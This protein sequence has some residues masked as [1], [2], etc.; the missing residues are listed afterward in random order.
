VGT[1]AKIAIGCVAVA[2]AMGI[3]A[4]VAVGGLAFWAKGKA[5]QFTSEQSRIEELHRKANA[6]RFAP[7]ADG[8]VRE[9]RLTRFLD[10]RRRVHVVYEKHKSELDAMSEKRQA[11]FGDVRKGFVLINELRLAQAQALADLAMSEDEYRFIVEQ[12]YKTMW[13]EG[14]DPAGVPAA[15]VA[16]FR[17]YEADINRYAM[18]GLEWIGL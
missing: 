18:G 9:E 5:D 1:G 4:V 8:T 7:P 15:N 12:V 11:D 10:V 16:L 2:V 6:N 14:K 3:V 17:K 13:S